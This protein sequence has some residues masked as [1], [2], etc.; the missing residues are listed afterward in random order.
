MSY[1]ENVGEV[2]T[3]N[4]CIGLEI[5]LERVKRTT[6]SARLSSVHRHADL[7]S[8]PEGRQFKSDPRNHP[9]APVL[10]LARSGQF[11]AN[12]NPPPRH[13]ANLLL[14][15]SASCGLR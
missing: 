8:Y 15:S 6:D 9:N 3:Q 2:V 1:E 10:E 13:S 14:L 11:L 7:N 4:P 12:P 5:V